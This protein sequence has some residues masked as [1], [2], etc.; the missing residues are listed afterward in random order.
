MN[1]KSQEKIQV[2]NY[3]DKHVVI[4][5]QKLEKCN[6][7]ILQKSFPNI[8]EFTLNSWEKEWRAARQSMIDMKF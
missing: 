2:I 6:A 1:E 3:L 7:A 5:N 4:K 8:D